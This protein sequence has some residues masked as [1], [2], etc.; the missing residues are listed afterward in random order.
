MRFSASAWAPA[1][2]WAA[3]RLRGRDGGGRLLVRIGPDGGGLALEAGGLVGRGGDDACRLRGRGLDLVGR[4]LGDLSRVDSRGRQR[5]LCLVVEPLGLDACGGQGGLGLAASG[6]YE[7]GRFPLARHAKLGDLALGGGAEGV[8]LALGARALL[9]DLGVEGRR[10]AFRFAG[11][12]REQLGRLAF[13]GLASRDRLGL[14]ARLDLLGLAPGLRQDLRNLVVG[15]CAQLLR[16]NVGACDRV[17]SVRVCAVHDVCRLLFGRPQQVFDARSESLVG[18][19][20][21]LVEGL[22]CVVECGAR[23]GGFLACLLGSGVLL[24]DRVLKPLH[25]RGDRIAVVSSHRDGEREQIVGHRF[26]SS[27][28]LSV[29][30]H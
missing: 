6:L 1:R 30:P 3:S 7:L 28:G 9:G 18:G 23:L 19:L 27:Q 25:V 16:C 11:G 14:R 4:V 24:S 15:T 29:T 22:F 21:A 20:F 5:L 17:L 2:I 13:D 12:L 8:D 26:S 10:D